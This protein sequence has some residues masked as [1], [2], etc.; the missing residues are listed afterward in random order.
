MV[1]DTDI[2]VEGPVKISMGYMYMH[3]RVGKY[4]EDKS[5]PPY[6]VVVEHRHGRIWAYQTPNKGPHEESKWSP[7]QLI[8]DWD[9]CAFKEVV[10]QL[11]ADQEPSVISLQVAV[12]NLRPRRY[13]Q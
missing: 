12:Q 4:K 6:L 1:P 5:N 3:E 9:D 7:S 11:K 8:Q 13:Y 2:S 10:I